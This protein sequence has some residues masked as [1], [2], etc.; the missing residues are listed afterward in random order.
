MRVIGITGGIG[1]GKSTVLQIIRKEQSCFVIEA[2]ALAH[3]LM[4]PGQCAYNKIV[5]AFGDSILDSNGAISRERLGQAVFGNEEQLAQLN[6]IVHPAVKAYILSDIEEKK[7]E[8]FACYVIEAALL[9]ED[10]YRGICDEIWYV[11]AGQEE[12]MKRLLS[13]RGGSRE[14]WE[15]I[16]RSQSTEDYYRQ[17]SDFFIDNSQNL[18]KTEYIVKQLLSKSR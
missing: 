10:G 4:E 8:G 16:I 3:D 17:Y 13:G 18:T 7:K 11:Y 5:K 9:I 15:N 12:R 14:K 2:D 1:S 6:E